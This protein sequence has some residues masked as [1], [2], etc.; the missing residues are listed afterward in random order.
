MATFLEIKQVLKEI[1]NL[2]SEVDETC[3]IIIPTSRFSSRESDIILSNIDLKNAFDNFQNYNTDKLELSTQKYREVALQHLG[4]MARGFTIIEPIVDSENGLTYLIGPASSEYSIFLLNEIADRFKA[5]GR[6]SIGDLRSRIRIILRHNTRRDFE[7]E[8]SME[9]LADFLRATTMKISS[10]ETFSISKFRDFASSF[11]FQLIYKKGIAVSEYTELEEM[12][13]LGNPLIHYSREEINT[14]PLRLYNKEVLDY[15]TMAMETR[16][17]F[18]MYISFYHVI[19]HYFDTI[20]RK[21]LTESIKEK[22]THPDFSY[23]NE[24][25]LYQLA[26]YIKK[27]MN[28]DD[29]SGKGNEFESL[30]YVLMEYVPLTELKNQIVSMNP[31]AVDYYQNNLVPFTTSNKTKI[32]WADTQG[33]YTNIATRIYETRN[34]L[35]HSKSEQAA[36]QYRPYKNKKDLVLEI[37]LIKSVAELVIIN[38]SE[39]L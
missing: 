19:E 35:V 33:A 29:N 34:A 31:N 3:D 23:K 32:A 30:K 26:K 11:E 24:D 15:Y 10:T 18:T 2:E 12:Y 14:P 7:N 25:K 20:F 5:E 22:I 27:H 36:N 4:P 13:S 16:D 1:F 6:R 8:N 17:P 38:S 39:I 9:I 21:K 28:S 37:A